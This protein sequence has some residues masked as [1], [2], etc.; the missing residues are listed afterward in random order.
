MRLARGLQRAVD[1]ADGVRHLVR[2]QQF[3]HLFECHVRGDARR[4][5]VLQHVELA[6]DAVKGQ[7]LREPAQLVLLVHAARTQR[8]LVQRRKAEG[9][10]RARLRQTCAHRQPLQHVAAVVGRG[11]GSGEGRRVRARPVVPAHAVRH[12][13]LAALADEDD[14]GL[15]QGARVGQELVDQFRADAGGVAGEQGDGGFHGVLVGKFS[16]RF[17]VW[18]SRRAGKGG[19]SL[20]PP[21]SAAATA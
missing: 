5:Q 19:Q 3:A 1:H 4:P 12:A 18:G 6:A 13:Y 11:L 2:R 15:G 9:V 20:N 14:V 8:A 7:Q 21:P 17:Q 10:G 16:A